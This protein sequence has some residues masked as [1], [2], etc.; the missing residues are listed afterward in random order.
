M[1]HQ[2]MHEVIGDAI[3]Y[4]ERHRIVY[5]LV[6]LVVVATIF[7]ANAAAFGRVVSLDLFLQLF[8]LA[9]MA[10]VAY[11]AAYPVDLTAQWST[12]RAPWLRMRWVLFLIGLAFATT[13]AQFIARGLLGEHA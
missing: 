6:L 11:C 13:L 12:L 3:R 8:L 1:E 5:N 9:V 2:D 4:W 10:N 7:V